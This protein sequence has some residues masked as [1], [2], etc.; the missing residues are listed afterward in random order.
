MLEKLE[1]DPAHLPGQND[2]ARW[3]ELRA[4]L[5]ETFMKHDRDHWARV[6]SGSDACVTPVLSFAEIETEPH[7]TERGSFYKV[8]DSVFPMPAPRFSRT[9]PGQPTPPR[10]PGEDNDAVLSDW[11]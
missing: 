6:F 7:N 8:G 9:Q 2:V 11:V 3:P 4:I 1:L 10:A 5:T